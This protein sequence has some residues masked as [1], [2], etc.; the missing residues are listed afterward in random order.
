VGLRWWRNG[1]RRGVAWVR[2]N[3]LL[4][5]GERGAPDAHTIIAPL[6]FQFGDSCFRRQIDQLSYFIYCHN[7]IA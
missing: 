6:D 2:H 4:G 3:D 1:G 7:A 5:R